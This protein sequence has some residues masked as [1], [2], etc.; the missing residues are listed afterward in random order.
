[1]ARSEEY[2]SEVAYAEEKKRNVIELN[3]EI[4]Y[5]LLNRFESLVSVKNRA[6]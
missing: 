1:M 5:R 2:V 3:H 4:F 6:E